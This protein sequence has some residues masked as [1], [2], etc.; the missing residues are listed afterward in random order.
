MVASKWGKRRKDNR[1][2]RLEMTPPD[3]VELRRL[4]DSLPPLPIG[5]PD[6]DDGFYEYPVVGE[7]SARAWTLM[8]DSRVS[9]ARF[10]LAEGTVYP[11]HSHPVAKEWVIVYSGRLLVE[12]RGAVS[13]AHFHGQESVIR[14]GQ[15]VHFNRGQIHQ[16]T[17]LDDT[18]LVAIT[19]PRDDAYPD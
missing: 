8:N 4:T 17:A 19:I 14:A 1:S 3:M 13:C 11:P 18:E 7:G 6:G 16:A 15:C 9:V 10:M 12:V 5:L 2:E